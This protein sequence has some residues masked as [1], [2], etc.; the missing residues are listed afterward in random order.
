MGVFGQ[1]GRR[2]GN[3]DYAVKLPHPLCLV[4][5]LP[6]RA[7]DGRLA[8]PTLLG[9]L[10]TSLMG[11]WP[12]CGWKVGHEPR[13]EPGAIATQMSKKPLPLEAATPVGKEGPE[14]RGAA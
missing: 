7:L 9:L 11:H 8:E 14:A 13:R 1:Y 6:A 5:L 4:V 10:W 3:T 2:T 12:W